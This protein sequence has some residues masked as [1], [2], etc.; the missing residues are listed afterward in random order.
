M[1]VTERDNNYSVTTQQL[2]ES[3]MRSAGTANVYGVEFERLLGY[4]AA[5]AE[6]TRESGSVIGNSLKNIFSR[7]TSVPEAV[8][9]MEEIGVS[10]N[11]M[12]GGLRDV[13][14]ILN[15]LGGKW[16]SLSREQ[17]QNLGVTIAGRHQLS[18]FMILMENW[19][20]ALTITDSAMRSNGSAMSENETY[21]DS[22]EAKLNEVKNAWTET[23]LALQE[24]VM[25]DGIVI[26]TELATSAIDLST[27]VVDKVGILPTIM[28]TAGI[29]ATLLGHNVN[30][31]AKN[32]LTTLWKNTK[33]VGES[34]YLMGLEAKKSTTE[35][36]LLE[37][38]LKSIKAVSPTVGLMAAGWGISKLIELYA[39]AKQRTEE[40]R[41][42]NEQ[43]IDSI[44]NESEQISQLVDEYERLSNVGEHQRN[45]AQ[46][47]RY[48]ELQNELAQLLP[49]VVTGEDEK[50]NAI[51][52]STEAVREHISALEEQAEW[53]AKLARDTAVAD[54][55]V[56]LEDLEKAEKKIRQAE[57][58]IEGLMEQQGAAA[59]KI[60]SGSPDSL[61]TKMA[62]DLSKSV[63][64]IIQANRSEIEDLREEANKYRENLENAYRIIAQAQSQDLSTGDYDWIVQQTNEAKVS[65]T[66][67][68]GFIESLTDRI[69]ILRESL[70]TGFSLDFVTNFDQLSAIEEVSTAINNGGTE[71]QKYADIL[72]N[73]GIEADLVNLILGYLRHTPQE[74]AAAARAMGQDVD[75]TNP[76]FS[77][78]GE[79]IENFGTIIVDGEDGLDDY[80]NK[81]DELADK[82]A[83]A[84]GDFEALSEIIYGLISAGDINSATTILQKDAYEA[85]SDELSPLNGLLESLA[86]GK[87][88]SAAEAMELIN[89]EEALADAISIESGQI[90]IN[91]DAVLKLRDA[92]LTSY[93]DMQKAAIA[94]AEQTAKKTISNLKNY[95]IEIEA[96]K[97]LAAAKQ[98]LDDRSSTMK[99]LPAGIAEDPAN[100]EAMATSR[101]VTKEIEELVGLYEEIENL[102]LM[103]ELTSQGLKEVGTSAEKASSSSKK[104]SDSSKQSA[105]DT[106]ESTYI[107][108]KYSLALEKV[109][110]ELE[111]QNSIQSKVAEHSK[112]YRNSLRKELK[113]LEKKSELIKKQ[114]K[115]LSKQIESGQIN[116]TGIVTN[117]VTSGYSTSSSSSSKSTASGGSTQAVIWNYLSSKGFS[118]N[119]VAGIMGNLQLE[120]NFNTNALNA[121]SGAFGLAQWL[122]GRKSSLQSYARSK[123]TSANNLQTQ[124][125]FLWKELNTTEKRT[126]DWL[127][128][129]QNASAATVAAQFDRMFERSEGTHI[130]QRQK[131]ANQI[132]NKYG[133]S[134]SS[135]SDSGGSV[136]DTSDIS[137][138]IAQNAQNLDQAK[139]DLIG[140]EL[141]LLRLNDQ[142]AE[143]PYLIVESHI[144]A[145]DHAMDKLEKKMSR[146]DYYQTGHE[147]FSSKWNKYQFEREK[148]L[149]QQ[150]KKYKESIKY[151]EK[152]I[153]TNKNLTKEQKKRLDDELIERQSELW[154]L[155]KQ[156]LDER[157]KIA[158]QLLSVYKEALSAQKDA[159]LASIDAMIKEI[160]EK[161]KEAEYKRKLKNEQADRQEILDEISQWAL[162]DSDMAKKRVKEL[163]EQLQEIDEAIEDMQH[164]KGLDDRKNALEEEKERIGNKYDDLIN[165]EQAFA[166]MRSKIIKGNTKSIEKELNTFYKKLGTM[167]EELGNSV[168]KNLQRSIKQMNSYIKD[169]SFDKVEVPHFDTGG[170]AR[171]KSSAGGLA[172]VHDKEHIFKPDDTDNL[173]R[174]VAL[175]EELFSHIKTPQTPQ[176]ATS[177]TSNS[178]KYDIDVNI[179]NMNGT[180]KD[181]DNALDRVVTKVKKRGGRL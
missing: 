154:N 24:D 58:V 61:D 159:A 108:D 39:D 84:S 149:G 114:A 3:L 26:F 11:D 133:G 155:E 32:G 23:A 129:N 171:V 60:S 113:L 30:D 123:G 94:E 85:L 104:A 175:A 9:A 31:L 181:I 101:Q 73:V 167:T 137:R 140:Y 12:D 103:S 130:P 127:K 87:S 100:R 21:L 156:I 53:E 118:D 62:F 47:E 55:T 177:N 88:I 138:E 143:I 5:I 76:I 169:P 74:I 162:N 83:E 131:Y 107:A 70:G 174:T 95:G 86:E 92:K 46:E 81:M 117:T 98:T 176:L 37:T 48:V 7:L 50:G 147:E 28:G 121:S 44:R 51:I 170:L 99:N 93:K 25:G 82:V 173:V 36:G 96:I 67:V 91:Q 19:E 78:L 79:T 142:I 45:N 10:I 161:E 178:V 105:K 145:F 33:G 20:Q 27:K 115:D 112:E 148:L 35:V 120:S 38:S 71:W 111:R 128:A 42:E 59:N 164:Q 136:I 54:I 43:S 166:N 134:S 109:N 124:L 77:A 146:I 63:G 116:Q 168:V 29:A 17:Q 125:D 135:S 141:E 65:I 16:S 22:Y 34:L 89:K 13:D 153:K 139:A 122:G 68:E 2:A 40:W 102:Q 69:A 49:S 4:S 163:T 90:K 1:K 72:A 8:T 64:G 110:L 15:D 126:L 160:D 18:R 57:D 6:V 158:D 132:L 66:E 14:D 152:E 157:I 97:N 144:A 52:A 172:V 56:N 75:A 151:I 179:E 106:S 150:V 119:I 165:D 41:K 80:G 180:K